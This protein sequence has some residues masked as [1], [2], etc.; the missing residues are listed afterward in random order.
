MTA[1][2]Y[3]VAPDVQT[4]LAAP[5]ARAARE[6]EAVT[7]AGEGV[8]FV[9]EAVGPA[10]ASRAEALAAHH[11]W[12][13]DDRGAG[14]PP[15]DRYCRLAE[16]IEGR[17]PPPAQPSLADGRRWPNPPPVPK[18]LW[19]LQVSYWRV[20]AAPVVDTAPQARQ[21][22]RQVR[23]PMDY[24]ALKQLTRQPLRPVKPQQPLDFGLFEAPMPE[25]PGR[26]MP[27]E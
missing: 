18:T 2:L 26:M 22:R 5:L 15:E 9:T 25:A 8:T 27:D 19:R 14:P 23:E 10:F 6:R 24:R 1:I 4:A 12:V 20:G 16:L 21:A 3:P 11:A 17:P 13:E 7:A